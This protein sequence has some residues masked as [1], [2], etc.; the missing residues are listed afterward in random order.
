LGPATYTAGQANPVNAPA[1]AI[2]TVWEPQPGPQ[3]LAIAAQFV[4]E[5]MYGGARGGGKS[6]YLLGDFLQDVWQGEKWRGIIFRRS[7]PELEEL[8]TR[9]QEIYLP[10]GAVWKA[11]KSTFIFP[12][13][14]T[15]KMRHVETEEDCNKYQ[16]HQYTWIGWDELTNWPNLKSYKKLKACLR[17]AL[18]VDNKRIRCSANPGGSG[19]HE[20]K[21]YFVDPAPK[22]MEL[23]VNR[24]VVTDPL[25]GVETVYETNKMFIPSRVYDNKKLLENDPGYIA[26]LREIGSPELV[27]AWLEGDWNVITG[28]Y[29]PEFSTN[30]HVLEPFAIPDHWL[31]FRSGDWGT[32]SPFCF[33]WH[34]VSDGYQVPNGPY[35]PSGAIVTYREFYGWNGHANQGLRWDAGRVAR[36]VLKMEKEAVNDNYSMMGHNGGPPMVEKITYS[37]IDPAAYK[38]DG[39]PSV[40]ESMAVNGVYCRKADNQRINGWNQVRER[41]CGED[42]DPEV[43]NGVGTPMWYVFKTCVHIIRTLPALQHDINNPEDADTK[44]EDHAPDALRYGLMSRP[45]KRPKPANDVAPPKT[46]QNL[47]MNDIWQEQDALD[48]AFSLI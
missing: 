47:T 12:S 13:G 44:G 10:L 40:A 38:Q 15:L 41:L 2:Q 11:S 29:F 37:V 48:T 8:I 32:A 22:G 46:L 18:G 1:I 16:G 3:S 6:D 21:E 39:G 28:A 17:S 14:A 35:I 27:R 42:G 45:W 34:A 24:D 7:H 31:R 26:R 25:T 33:L 5:L 23:I 19:H 30:K 4:T 9:A 36:A 20:V 43:D